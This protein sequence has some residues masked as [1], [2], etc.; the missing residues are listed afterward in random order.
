MEFSWTL[1]RKTLDQMIEKV[2]FK[3]LI[4]CMILPL[5]L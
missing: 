5:M 1:I 4:S 3:E 2:I